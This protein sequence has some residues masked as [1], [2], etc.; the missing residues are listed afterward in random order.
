MAPGSCTVEYNSWTYL[1]RVYSIVKLGPNPFC[2]TL[3]QK[4]KSSFMLDKLMLRAI[5]SRGQ[6]D[7]R[8]R[9][10]AEKETK[11]KPIAANPKSK[12]K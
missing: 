4:N 6:I 2:Q 5:R 3:R 7:A 11:P 12:T 10:G 1:H 8:L 9:N